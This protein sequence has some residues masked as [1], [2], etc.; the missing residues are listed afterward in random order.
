M[1]DLCLDVVFTH[2][3]QLFVKFGRYLMRAEVLNSL[4]VQKKCFDGH[5]V[6]MKDMNMMAKEQ[7]STDHTVIVWE[8]NRPVVIPG[9]APLDCTWL[10]CCSVWPRLP[11]SASARS[12]VCSSL[13]IWVFLGARQN[14]QS[15]DNIVNFSRTKTVDL[16][17][18]LCCVT[19]HSDSGAILKLLRSI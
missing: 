10:K 18:P 7:L 12:P 9:R 2:S 1:I 6:S 19:S 5:L 14:T 15:F 16:S 4:R 8:V 13:A 11:P 17:G 3:P